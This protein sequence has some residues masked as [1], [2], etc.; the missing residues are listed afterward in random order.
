[1]SLMDLVVDSILSNVMLI[2]QSL[3]QNQLDNS[4]FRFSLIQ[5]QFA[6]EDFREN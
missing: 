1:M 5:E 3:G 6:L 2:Y 4:M